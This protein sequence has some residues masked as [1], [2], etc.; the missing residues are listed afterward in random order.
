MAK[1]LLLFYVKRL[2]I[3][4]K[5]CWGSFAFGRKRLVETVTWHV[6]R[7]KRQRFRV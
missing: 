5:L 3:K 4:Q 7:T 6:W 1:M 2:L